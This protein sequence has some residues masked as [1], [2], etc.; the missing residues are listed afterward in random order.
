MMAQAVKLG[1]QTP[2]LIAV[3]V[4]AVK[5]I[6]FQDKKMVEQVAAVKVVQA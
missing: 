1:H 4:E 6:T 2:L 3:A 5:V